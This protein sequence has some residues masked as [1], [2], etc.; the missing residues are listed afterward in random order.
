MEKYSLIIGR[1]LVGLYFLVP[2]IM[3][4]VAWDMHIGLMEKHGMIFVPVLL[5]LAGVTQIAASACILVNRYVAPAAFLLAL[6]VVAINVNLHDFWNYTGQEGA[7]EMQNFIKNLGILGGLL[8]LA[9]YN[10][11]YLNYFKK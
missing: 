2:G 3:K 7:H 9:A 4:F 11:K 10:F 6:M 1:S 5:V 8:V